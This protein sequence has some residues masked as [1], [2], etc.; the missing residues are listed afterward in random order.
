MIRS[1]AERAMDSLKQ[2]LSQY[3]SIASVVTDADELS[4]DRQEYP[5]LWISR[6][7]ETTLAIEKPLSY[8]KQMSVQLALF[9]QDA[10][11]SESALD[12]AVKQIKDGLARDITMGGAVIQIVEDNPAVTSWD[13]HGEIASCI[14]QMRMT[15]SYTA[16]A[17]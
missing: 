12:L 6:S 14:I 7:G 2:Y 16:G 3:T 8:V 11:D 4:G 10:E 15:Y 5:A 17:A 1:G 13:I 9:V